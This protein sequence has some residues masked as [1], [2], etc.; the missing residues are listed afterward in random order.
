MRTYMFVFTEPFETVRYASTL[1]LGGEP[2][3]YNNLLSRINS[4]TTI[5]QR[6]SEVKNSGLKI[7]MTLMDVEFYYI[8]LYLI[9]LFEDKNNIIEDNA[10]VLLNNIYQSDSC[11]KFSEFFNHPSEMTFTECLM[12]VKRCLETSHFENRKDCLAY[13]ENGIDLYNRIYAQPTST[14]KYNV[15]EISARFFVGINRQ[16]LSR[17][18]V[19]DTEALFKENSDTEGLYMKDFTEPICKTYM[20]SFYTLQTSQKEDTLITALINIREMFN[21]I[22]PET[23]HWMVPDMIYSRIEQLYPKFMNKPQDNGEE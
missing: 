13:I 4:V 5:Q 3:L 9:K 17:W 8:Y 2:E 6:I 11:F 7:A 18:G 12:Q 1:F 23:A 21:L 16:L 20:R 14:F 10:F 15:E 22:S 19:P